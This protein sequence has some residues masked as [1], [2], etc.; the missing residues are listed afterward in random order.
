ML[1]ITD[2]DYTVDKRSAVPAYQQIIASMV[3]RIA[4][5]EWLVGDKLPSESALSAAYGVSR[6][7]LRLA[8][9]HLE[10]RGIVEAF[11][12]KGIYVKSNPRQVVQNLTFPTAGLPAENA[13]LLDSH[14]LTFEYMA[15]S[16]IQL[17]K[18]LDAAP[19]ETLTHLRRLF[20]FE[21]MPIGLNDVWL[22]ASSVPGLKDEPFMDG[23]LSKTMFYKYHYDIVKI[24]NDIQC[25]RLDA[26]SARLLET[27]FD[28]PALQINSQ[29]LLADGTPIQYA[30][31]LWLADY[32]QFHYTAVK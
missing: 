31:T 21:G 4:S 10:Q 29:S 24:E 15:V 2:Q 12:G 27:T 16:T 7:T 14:I 8:L 13:T 23:R 5:K 20:L 22:K 17:A 32:T 25:V 11:Q 19:N 26:P 9:S 28:S 1:H 30:N 3:K 6:V 18:K